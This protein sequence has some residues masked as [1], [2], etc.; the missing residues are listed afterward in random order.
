MA[1]I[2]NKAVGERLKSKREGLNYPKSRKF[3]MDASVDPSQYSKI[4]KGKL[5]ITE[6]VLQKLIDKHGLAKDYILY[7]INVPRAEN[8]SSGTKQTNTDVKTMSV[9][10]HLAMI[11]DLSEASKTQSEANRLQAAA[12]NTS[13]KNIEAL[14][15][16]IKNSKD[17][18]DHKK[19]INSNGK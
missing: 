4:E 7:G 17:N 19:K 3:A 6:N 11:A 10:K 8:N 12:N 1:F 2:D 18:S 14:I 16:K 5:P 15:L 13:C 9:D